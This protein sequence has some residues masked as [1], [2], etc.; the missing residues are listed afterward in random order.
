LALNPEI[1]ICD[2][3]VSALDVTIQAQILNLLNHLKEKYSITILFISHDLSVVKYMS[4]RVIILNNGRVEEV[5]ETD[6]LF[7]E[8]NEDYTKKL[9]FANDF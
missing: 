4:D 6:R 2:E 1:L 7:L 5:N 9:L 3:S 8:P